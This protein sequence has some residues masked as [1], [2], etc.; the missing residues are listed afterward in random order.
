MVEVLEDA[1]RAMN[2]QLEHRISY[3]ISSSTPPQDVFDY[4]AHGDGNAHLDCMLFI[5][6]FYNKQR[7]DAER[8]PPIVR[9]LNLAHD[10]LH[11][12][13][14]RPRQLST[15][16]LCLKSLD[17]DWHIPLIVR[18]SA[19]ATRN[20]RTRGPQAQDQ[21]NRRYREWSNRQEQLIY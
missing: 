15:Y 13:S 21:R 11:N 17:C 16:D 7:F 14:E 1:I 20:K 10:Y 2:Q 5:S 19:H 6:I 12:I 3:N 4:V 18:V 9:N 8:P